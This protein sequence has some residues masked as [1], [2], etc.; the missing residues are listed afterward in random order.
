MGFAVPAAIAAALAQPQRPVLCFV[1]DGGLGMTLAE[2][3][4]ISRLSLDVTVVVFNDSGLSLIEI[5]QEP[6][7]GGPAAVRYRTTDFATIAQGM[8]MPS[9]VVTEPSGLD[10][11]LE[12]PWGGPRLID[13]RVN[14][15]VYPH[16][17]KVTRG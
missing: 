5:K 6:H 10:R 9:A 7:H 16:V 17:I 13:A 15:A 2:L 3:E 12:R 4:T 11:Q 14:P 1:G 8:G